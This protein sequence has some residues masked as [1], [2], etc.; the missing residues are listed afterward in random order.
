MSYRRDVGT[1]FN[2]EEAMKRALERKTEITIGPKSTGIGGAK[3]VRKAFLKKM[4][5]PLP[6][7]PPPPAPPPKQK[8]Y[9]TT[10]PISVVK[11]ENCLKKLAKECLPPEAFHKRPD[12][13]DWFLCTTCSVAPTNQLQSQIVRRLLIEARMKLGEPLSEGDKKIGNPWRPD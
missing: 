8:V 3:A 1:G 12:D 7:P 13:N 6:A 5:Q 10:P 9:P 11:C 2:S 4:R